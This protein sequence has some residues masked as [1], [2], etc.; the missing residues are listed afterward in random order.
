M[1]LHLVEHHPFTCL[2]VA[3]D[4][5][6]HTA[7]A[8]P[9]G[10]CPLPLDAGT[11]AYCFNLLAALRA[12]KLAPADIKPIGKVAYVHHTARDEL[13]AQPRAQP[14]KNIATINNRR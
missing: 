6:A 9:I 3:C 4:G 7:R 14:P 11:A 12:E 1:G 10:G 2:R 5:V 8:Q 13:L